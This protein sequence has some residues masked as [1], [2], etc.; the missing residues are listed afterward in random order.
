MNTGDHPDREKRIMKGTI[1]N[2]MGW[3]IDDNDLEATEGNVFL[4][5]MPKVI[6]V[7]FYEFTQEHGHG[8]E[9]RPA[10]WRINN[11]PPGV[12]PI[13]PIRRNWEA[14]GG[15]KPHQRHRNRWALFTMSNE[16]LQMRKL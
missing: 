6:Y 10:Q 7:Q 8:A 13:K 5:K 4:K 9:K 16:F 1:G 14:P 3:D 11:L 12:Y 15:N 2:V